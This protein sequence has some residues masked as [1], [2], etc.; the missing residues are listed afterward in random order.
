MKITI[1]RLLDSA[2][3]L[4]TEVGQAIP[5]FFTYMAEFVEQATRSLRNG[6][7]FSDNFDCQVK[8]VKLTSGVASEVSATKAVTGIIP[9]RVVSQVHGLESFAWWYSDNGKLTVK[10][11]FTS[12]PTAPVDVVLVILF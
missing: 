3:Y 7:T 5:D 6:L 11:V 9:V 8:E 10:A 1:T 12:V 2:K 4:A